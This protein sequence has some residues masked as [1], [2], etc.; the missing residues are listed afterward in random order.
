MSKFDVLYAASRRGPN[1]C[2]PWQGTIDKRGYGKCYYGG[3]ATVASRAVWMEERGH[4]PGDL[5]VD[6]LCYNPPCVNPAHLRLLTRSENSRGIR[7]A[8]WTHCKHGHEFTEEN[9]L[10]VNGGRRCRTCQNLCYRR[11]HAKKAGRSL[12]W[13]EET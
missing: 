10:R 7:K 6:H 2:W 3:T 13:L 4:I 12:E 5:T 1:E 11:Y 9:T 8:Q